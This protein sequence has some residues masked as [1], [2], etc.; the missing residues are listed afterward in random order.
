MVLEEPE[1]ENQLNVI[2]A[3]WEICWFNPK[4]NDD[5]LFGRILA[6]IGRAEGRA[7][8]EP[9]R[10]QQHVAKILTENGSFGRHW[11][12]WY[13]PNTHEMYCCT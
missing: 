6:M 10:F 8:D 7:E 4:K 3:T 11:I 12:Q 9:D 2:Y 13:A 5:A 1:S